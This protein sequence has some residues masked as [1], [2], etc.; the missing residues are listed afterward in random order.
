MFACTGLVEEA[1]M[2]APAVTFV[3]YIR[4]VPASNLGRDIDLP[5]RLFL[6]FFVSLY[7]SFPPHKCE[8]SF[9]RSR[10]PRLCRFFVIH[11]SLPF[12]GVFGQRSHRYGI[13]GEES[14]TGTDFSPRVSLFPRQCFPTNALY[15]YTFLSPRIFNLRIYSVAK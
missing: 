8:D 3:T 11:Y 1:S 12:D 14:G 2:L 15:S 10:R 7:C 13:C 5:R 4:E 6:P 9:L